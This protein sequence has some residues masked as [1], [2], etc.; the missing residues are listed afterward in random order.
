MKNQIKL[1]ITVLIAVF[2]LPSLFSSLPEGKGWGGA[3]FAQD[4]HFSQFRETPMLINP[5][6]TALNKDVRV[7]LNYKDQWRSVSSPFKTFG[8][9]GEFAI[10]HKRGKDNY[11]GLGVQI[12]SDKAG[13]AKMGTTMGLLSLSGIIKVSDAHKLS[14]GISGGVGQRSINTSAVK[15]GSQ[16]DGANYNGALASGEVTAP[17]N[18]VFPDL[19]GGIAWSYG[20]GESTLSSN[21]G[22]KATVGVSAFHFGIPKYS[23]YASAIEKLDTK[24]IGH[25]SVMIGIPNSNILIVPELIYVKQGPMQEINA[26]SMFKFITQE[27]SKFTRFKKPAAFSIGAHYRVGDAL[28]FTGMYEYSNYAIGI[29][30]D[31]NFSKLTSASKSRGGIE[32]SLRFV[33]P[34]QFSTTRSRI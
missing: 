10:N 16:Y 17:T 26:G 8:V 3:S 18:F 11:L 5:A 14:V 28:I 22:I 31:T 29:S 12:L 20:K 23:Y 4:F 2:F 13:D 27:E 1:R 24:I 7:I 30:Y 34:N 25:A 9:S 19:G 15:W 6:Q 32:I 21:N 33:T